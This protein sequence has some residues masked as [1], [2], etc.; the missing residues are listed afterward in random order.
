[1]LKK[2]SL[3]ILLVGIALTMTACAGEDTNTES[4]EAENDVE[5][6]ET[7]GDLTVDL[8][9]APVSLDPHAANDGNSLYV[10]NAMYDTLVQMN[11]DL[12]IEPG[13][14]ESLEQIEDTVW[15]AK[16]REG[17]TFHDG[18]PLNAEVVKANLDRV[19]DPDIASP[20]SFLFDMIE[21]VD[22]IDDYTVHIE[23]EFPFSALPSHLAH[24]G[25][26]MISLE[27]I[28]EDYEAVENGEEP[29]TTV[30]QEPVGTG[31]FKYDERVNGEYVKLVKNEDYWGEQAKMDAVTFKVVPEDSAR[32]AEL[33]TGEADIIYPVNPNDVSQIDENEGTH[34][35]Q[36]ESSSMSYLGMN[37]EIEPFNNVNV[38]R[39]I[40]M[41][42]NK[43]ELIEGLLNGVP[44]PADGPLA[45]T[46][47][48]YSE[49]TEPV[50]YNPEEA[51]ELLN[52]AGYEDGFETTI[53]TNDDTTTDIA[54][55]IQSQLSEIGIDASIETREVGAYLELTGNGSFDMF[56]GSW[57]TVT[58]DADYGLYPMFH[59]S[60][61]GDSGNRSFF[62]N[63]QVDN[64]L[65]E[66]RRS[67]DEE[68]RKALY[69]EA[70]QIIVD[71]AT[72][73]P[74]YHSV[75]L[76]GLQDS[77]NGFFQYPSSFPYLRDV[78][79]E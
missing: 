17:V 41:A 20:V 48:G 1:M 79:I 34:V 24:P 8:A 40:S 57:G 21:S 75:L 64:L 42:I 6:A 9:S 36:S 38:R 10:M 2:L 43:D 53:L 4:D 16:I 23:T 67:T 7:S 46:V 18:S 47:R 78:E 70:Q 59:S 66:A 49:D 28:E 56:V 14:A 55:L 50:E 37:N 58:M 63:E 5:T 15:E 52:E 65:E 54:E 32:I 62:D 45:P 29:F 33:R 61:A 76:A 44:L 77:V 51:Q 35:H 19:R 26:H 73:V 22:V 72:I 69:E 25:G 68:E 31:Y 74:L 27:S 3:L 13:L 30:N 60:N 11:K 12:E 71:E 39:A